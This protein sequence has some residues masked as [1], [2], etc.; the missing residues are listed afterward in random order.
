MYVGVNNVRH[1]EIQQPLVL[2]P[3]AFMRMRWLFKSWKHISPHKQ[4]CCLSPL[5]SWNSG[6]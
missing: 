3:S 4:S 1:T 2:E 5:C 6:A